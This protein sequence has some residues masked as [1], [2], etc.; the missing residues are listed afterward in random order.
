MLSQPVVSWFVLLVIF[1]RFT[2]SMQNDWYLIYSP[3]IFY[4]LFTSF[5]YKFVFFFIF[6]CHSKAYFSQFI[7]INIINWKCTNKWNYALSTKVNYSERKT[8]SCQIF[9]PRSMAFL[10]GYQE[11]NCYQRHC[12]LVY[13]TPASGAYQ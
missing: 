12:A 2:V 10:C 5:H 7:S 6:L 4:M 11:K 1:V 3:F 9:V 13:C 8:G